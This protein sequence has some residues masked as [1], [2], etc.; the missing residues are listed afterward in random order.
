[1]LNKLI[2][3]TA[4]F[5]MNYGYRENQISYNEVCSIISTAKE[6]GLK[7]FDTA[8]SYGESEDLLLNLTEPETLISKY[9]FDY[10]RK[11]EFKKNILKRK[12]FNSLLLHNPEILYNSEATNY[13]IDNIKLKNEKLKAGVSVYTVDQFKLA[14]KFNFDI[15]QCPYNVLDSR[16]S[17]L[18]DESNIE[19]H[20]R[21]IF[22]QGLL[23]TKDQE[24]VK[25]RCPNLLPYRQKLDDY[26]KQYGMS[27]F[28][29]CLRYVLEN[30]NINGIVIG[31]SSIKQ[32]YNII[33]ILESNNKIML[34]NF[35]CNDTKVLDPRSWNV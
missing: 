17:S 10:E 25:E 1:M 2:L 3:G 13:F 21:S 7:L 12:K 6:T 32:L 28:E 18:I 31:I 30:K 22:L 14:L 15:I 35:D 20:V 11:E 4:N 29:Y 33:N 27:N 16:F 23:V 9:I 19:V 5:G 8:H 26:S 34:E 24:K